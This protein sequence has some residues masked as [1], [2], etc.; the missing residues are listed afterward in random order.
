MTRPVHAAD[1]Q[2]FRVGDTEFVRGP[3]RNSS[4]NRLW[5]QKPN[6]LVDQY[7]RLCDEFRPRTIVEL[8][9]YGGGSTALLALLAEPQKLVALELEATPPTGLA[10][11]IEQH[12]LTDVVVPCYG[13]DQ[14]DRTRVRDIVAEELGDEPLDLVIDD[15][16]HM[17]EETRASFEVLFPRVRPGGLFIIEDWACDH[18]WATS[19]RAGLDAAP[20][21]E[22]ATLEAQLTAIAAQSAPVRPLTRLVVELMVAR[23][24]SAGAIDDITI[25]AHW[26]AVRRGNADA[27][28]WPYR[29]SDYSAMHLGLLDH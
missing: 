4:A 23:A 19:F 17:L 21:A 9:I 7:V 1:G 29:L 25:D 14:S 28:F 22:R 5:I 11:F 18:G 10:E 12:E 3:S 6:G 15:A 26:V 13:V 24:S 20:P 16:S 8:G 27:G 2:T